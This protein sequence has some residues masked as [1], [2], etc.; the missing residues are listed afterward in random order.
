MKMLGRKHRPFFR[1]V[2]I[3]SRQPRD[4]RILEE[5]GT[6]DPMMKDKANRVTMDPDRIKYWQSVGAQ[7]SEKVTI[8]MAKYVKKTEAIAKQAAAEPPPAAETPAS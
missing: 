4:G 1:I 7:V 5:L 8:L 3:D 6:Y 2:A